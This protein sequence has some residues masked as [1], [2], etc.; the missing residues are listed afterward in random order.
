MKKGWRRAAAAFFLIVSVWF[1]V[2]AAETDSVDGLI[3]Q[4][5]LQSG[6]YSLLDQL[7]EGVE[8]VDSEAFEESSFS[9]WV[10]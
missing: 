7:P 3:E 4:Q 5:L 2:S 1:P 10:H 9:D 8:S 6:Y